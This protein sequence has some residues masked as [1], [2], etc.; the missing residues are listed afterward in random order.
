MINFLKYSHCTIH[1]TILTNCVMNYRHTLP[2][3]SRSFSL[4]MYF[5]PS[6]SIRHSWQSVRLPLA[7]TLWWFWKCC[8]RG[9]GCKRCSHVLNNADAKKNK[10]QKNNIE[11]YCVKSIT[12]DFGRFHQASSFLIVQPF[13][14]LRFCSFAVRTAICS[15]PWWG[16]WG[17]NKLAG[18]Q[19]SVKSG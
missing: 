5:S 14:N 6:K 7:F 2:N 13:A 17:K 11:T 15:T 19:S 1:W 4:Y 3:K 9:C 16:K 8:S 18:S 12:L 10:K